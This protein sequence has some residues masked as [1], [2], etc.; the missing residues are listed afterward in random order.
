ME[1]ITV[2]TSPVH[3]SIYEVNIGVNSYDI[4]YAQQSG[5]SI[6]RNKATNDLL[7]L[8][9]DDEAKLEFV[10][11]YFNALR[12]W[13]FAYISENLDIS[14]GSLIIPD[15]LKNKFISEVRKHTLTAMY[16]TIQI[17]HSMNVKIEVPQSEVV[18]RPLLKYAK[19]IDHYHNYCKQILKNNE[20]N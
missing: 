10:C 20:Q 1:T 18:G 12:N 19:A 9:P 4:T 13:H 16:G 7:E 14:V 17:M 2:I 6:H 3:R 11:T 5:T 15:I 8:N